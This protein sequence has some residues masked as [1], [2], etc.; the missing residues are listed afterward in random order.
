MWRERERERERESGGSECMHE[1][2]GWTVW[3]EA[4]IDD[5]SDVGSELFEFLHFLDTNRA[6]G[7]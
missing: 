4:A 6:D 1:M 5:T 2:A 7:S 3:E